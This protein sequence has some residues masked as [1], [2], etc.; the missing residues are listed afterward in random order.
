[1]ICEACGADV[2]EEARFCPNCGHLL[3]TVEERRVVSV[4][5]ADLVGFT[6]LAE[7][8]DPET[9]KHLV[10][11]CFERLVADITSFGGSVDK[12]VGDGIVALFGAPVAHEDD[13]ERATRVAMRM[14]Q[15][16]ATLSAELDLPV[17][18]RIGVN[19]G[20]VLV[21]ATRGGGDYTA[22][23]DTVN[24]AARLEAAAAPGEVLVGPATHAATHDVIA[25]E[26]RGTMAVRGRTGAVVVHAA[27]S[28]L[29]PPGRR[30]R[31]VRTPLV[32]RD[33]ELD[34]LTAAVGAAVRRSH[35]HLML[36][37][38]EAGMGKSR[39]VEEV[40]SRAE[41]DPGV[42]VLET[43]CL[44]YG[45]TSP[46][47]P[48]G[49]ALR[50]YARAQPNDP[51]DVVA[52]RLRCTVAETLDADADAVD[53]VVAGLGFFVDDG[54]AASAV[55]R[56]RDAA[57]A[58]LIAFLRALLARRPVVFALSDVHWADR[59]LLEVVEQLLAELR[60]EPLA[61]MATSRWQVDE[62][63]WT[64]PPGRHNTVI[65]NLTP[66]EADATAR[67][68]AALLGTDVSDDLARQLHARSGG[69]PFFLEEL[70]NLLSETAG[71]A[72]ERGLADGASTELPDTLRGL[73]TARL[74]GLGRSERAMV[75]D[76]SVVG[77]DGPLYALLLMAATRG[78]E[79]PEQVFSTL[80]AKDLFETVGTGW[81]FRSDLVREVAYTTLTKTDRARRHADIA[82]WLDEH[83]DP[84]AGQLRSASRR[85]YH[86]TYAERLRRELGDVDGLP[87]DLTERA[88]AAL[89][90]FGDLASRA[91]SHF[92]TRKA[93]DRLLELAPADQLDRRLAAHLGRAGASLDLRELR[94]ADD[95]I[96]A[97]LE[98]ARRVGDVAAEARAL[99]LR[100]EVE[101][102]RGELVAARSTIEASLAL[103]RR[104][105]DEPGLAEGLRQSGMIHLRE[106]ATDDAVRSFLGALDISRRIGDRAGE[107]WCLQ[108]LAWSAFERGEVRR[109]E[110]RLRESIELFR[111]IGD[112]PGIGWASGL[113]AYIRF[114][115]GHRQEA[116]ELALE[117]EHD[118]GRRGDR[119]GHGLMSVLLAST[120]L[121][122]GRCRDAVGWAEAALD[123]FRAI[124]DDF[125]RVQSL[126]VMGR[127]LVAA[128][129]TADGWR[130]LEEARRIAAAMPERP[131]DRLVAVAEL[132]AATHAGDVERV[133]ALAHV[134]ETV[135]EPP[136]EL[137][138]AD[139]EVS[140][141]LAALQSG[142]SVLADLERACAETDPDQ[143]TAHL[144]S[145]LGLAAAVEGRPDR[146]LA[147]VAGVV[148]NERAT[149]LDRTYALTAAALASVA[150]GDAAGAGTY[151]ARAGAVADATDSRLTRAVVDL[152]EAVVLDVSGHSDALDRR[153][154]VEARLGDLGVELRG[155]EQ[156]FHVAASGR[157]APP[158]V[159]E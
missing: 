115:Q 157:T 49:E 38:G 57:V 23:G 92:A 148:G 44:P 26:P 103:W 56:D 121:W 112:R 90:E 34:L 87:A 130:R 70:A 138:A 124:E 20:E 82:R 158:R 95:D 53:R 66:L 152:A 88:L 119:W 73:V 146:A 68:A 75:D 39:L 140:T 25:Y 40:W 55:V 19:T 41:V 145:V 86:Y 97:A 13:A 33:P 83:R 61:V 15:T 78:E 105:G 17:R 153:L 128:G 127:A 99:V 100:S 154:A 29:N 45:E 126:A 31:R 129:S 155:W 5:F 76:A 80:V 122:S 141:A 69:N 8:L 134:W 42:V 107:A 32:G 6:T 116:E 64:V 43:R 10:D 3:S 135:E 108:N 9:V 102:I 63:R 46:F 52:D 156:V 77:R 117:V 120:A 151:L 106:G 18:L 7:S 159:V 54:H 65:V 132:G 110:E 91:D 113:M 50:Q 21:G 4:L 150:R 96:Y 98:L 51:P 125:G 22:M 149:F 1:M 89:D 35:A 131:L 28:E 142:R 59:A 111:S 104:S 11:R 37:V 139:Y 27:L 114:Y 133:E 101:Q 48:I 136:G 2:P 93:Y 58:E 62:Q 84:G 60:A 79:A 147:V 14:Q 24:L 67:L 137:G 12:I 71:Q 118:T 85:A 94:A 143:P 81:R 74:D 30:P 109:A 144:E 36:V 123:R 16:M 47:W 72:G